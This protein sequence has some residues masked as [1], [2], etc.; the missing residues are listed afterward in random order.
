MANGD[1]SIS[2]SDPGETQDLKSAMPQRFQEML[3]A[4][5]TFKVVNRVAQLPAG[6]TQMKQMVANMLQKS[7]KNFIIFILTLLVLLPFLVAWRMR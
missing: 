2:F 4:Y 6:Y 1:Y 3:S 7:G 5:E